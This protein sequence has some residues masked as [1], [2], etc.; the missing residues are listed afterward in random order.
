MTHAVQQ[1]RKAPQQKRSRATCEAILQ[2]AGEILARDGQ[3]G[4]NTNHVAEQAGVSIGSLYQYFPNKQ[5]IVVALIRDFRQE[6]LRDID[7]AAALSE[8]VGLKETLRRIVRAGLRHHLRNPERVEALERIEAELPPDPEVTRQKAQIHAVIVGVLAQHYVDDPE[9][10]ARDLVA[11][12]AGLTHAAVTA[13]ERDFEA[14]A[15][16]LDRATLGYLG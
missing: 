10:V 6:M 16:R 7:A 9:V 4:L 12:C 8:Q 3:A 1:P 15:R 14:L 11:L 5:A 13:G 2:A